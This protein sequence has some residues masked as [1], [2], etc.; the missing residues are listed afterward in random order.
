[1]QT[2][3]LTNAYII[4][5]PLQKSDCQQ[6]SC[7]HSYISFT[8]RQITEE[9][10]QARQVFVTGAVFVNHTKLSQMMKR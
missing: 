3:A 8:V 9:R 6:Y 1:M 10:L 4:R 2:D 5:R 7:R